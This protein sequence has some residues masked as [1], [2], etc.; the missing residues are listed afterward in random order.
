M[1]FILKAFYSLPYTRRANVFCAWC[2]EATGYRHGLL[3]PSHGICARCSRTLLAN[4]RPQPKKASMS[5]LALRKT[6]AF[7]RLQ[8]IQIAKLSKI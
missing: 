4:V 6:R 7:V 8:R 5:A 1:P 3:S 2:G